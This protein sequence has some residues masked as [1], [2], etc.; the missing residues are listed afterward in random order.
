MLPE[1]AVRVLAVDDQPAFL[2]A[3]REVVEATPGFCWAGQARSGREAMRAVEDVRPDLV[4]IDVR[5]PGI[6]GFE[7]AR[8]ITGV[9]QDVVAVLVTADEFRDGSAAERSGAEALVRKQDFGPG[10]LRGLW[11]APRRKTPVV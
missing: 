7:T 2:Q 10:L 1:D 5:M 4:L 9:H 8:L 3:A 6:D 11:S